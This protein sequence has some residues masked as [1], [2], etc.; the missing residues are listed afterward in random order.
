M[1][2][3]PPRNLGRLSEIAQVA[4]RHGFGYV[5]RR[6]RLGD[7]IPGRNGDDER[8]GRARLGAR[9]PPARD[10]RRARPD[11]RQVRPA[12]L[13]AAGRAP[14]GHHRRAARPPGRRSPVPATSWPRRRSRRSSDQPIERLFL[15]FERDAAGGGVDRPG[16]PRGAPERPPGRGQG[17]A[18]RA[19]RAR[20]RP[21]SRC[22]TRPRG[23]PRSACARST[24]STRT[25]SSTS[26]RARSARSST[27]GSRA[28]T[29]RRS[30]A[31]SPATRTCT[32]PRVYWSY[33]RTRVLTLEYLEGTQVADV[34]ELEFT[35][36]ERRRL[37]YLMTEAW[38]TMIFRHG[39]F[40][41]DPHP[42]NILVLGSPEQIGLVDFGLAGKL[43]DSDIAKADA[44]LHRR[45][46][47]ERRRAAEAPRRPRRP[48][49]ARAR[50][51]V[52]RRA[53]RALLPL[54][55]RAAVRHRPAPGDPRG[56]RA[57]LPHQPQAADAL[58][59][60]RPRGRDARLGR[61]R[62]LSGLQRLRGREAVRAQPDDRALHAAGG[63]PRERRGRRST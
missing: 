41:G 1:A 59:A 17:A 40:H 28:A 36:D 13:D 56:L 63:S 48:L 49:P 62:A 25:S 50:G 4:V 46:E 34:D 19:R 26:S 16:A 11:L 38:M 51:A 45:R 44:A 3:A 6:N 61:D 31:T 33:T 12:A 24:S 57:D 20:S 27:T 18:A 21:T 10:A 15:E 8:R 2:Q 14:A 52:R 47:R 58:P 30:G 22:S 43:T 32:I 53:A 37:A 39:F 35:M 29:P 54:L 7:L 42:A 60:A 9:P 5:F 23:S 55:R